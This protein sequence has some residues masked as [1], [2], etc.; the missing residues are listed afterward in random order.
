[1]SAAPAGLAQLSAL[2]RVST[3]LTSPL[4]AAPGPSLRRPSDCGV[5]AAQ[6]ARTCWGAALP[7]TLALLLAS[8]ARCQPE[9]RTPRVPASVGRPGLAAGSWALGTLLTV[10]SEHSPGPRGK[11]VRRPGRLTCVA[12]LART[13]VAVYL[14]QARACVTGAAGTVVQV[15]LTVGSWGVGGDTWGSAPEPAPGPAPAEP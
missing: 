6:T 12:R 10:T 3:A 15:D 11:A 4:P 8:A 7:W 13:L 2:C 9:T 5:P 14:V 1:M